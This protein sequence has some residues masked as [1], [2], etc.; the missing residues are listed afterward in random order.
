MGHSDSGVGVLAPRTPTALVL[1]AVL[2]LA[3]TPLL[4]LTLELLAVVSLRAW[5][6]K[7][8]L[9]A[10]VGRALLVDWKLFVGPAGALALLG[11]WVW[12][13]RRLARTGARRGRRV[14]FHAA[15]VALTLLTA[16]WR[17]GAWQDAAEREGGRRPNRLGLYSTYP[18]H[19]RGL[20]RSDKHG[21]PAAEL[22]IN[23][24]GFRDDAREYVPRP[25]VRR[26]LV[27]GDAFVFG[28][29]ISSAGD[30]LHAQLQTALDRAGGGPWEVMNLAQQPAALWYY[31]AALRA[32]LRAVHAD[33]LVL[34]H[35]RGF[36]LEPFE[37]RRLETVL[38]PGENAV[39][40]AFGIDQD[41]Q[42]LGASIGARAARG[43]GGGPSASG[44]AA[45]HAA[46]A[47]LVADADLAGA[48]LFVWE[49]LGHDPFFDP[50][51]ACPGVSFVAGDDLLG[52]HTTTRPWFWDAAL[53]YPDDGR[54]TPFANR[55]TAEGLARRIGAA[56]ASVAAR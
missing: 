46:V 13:G 16:F 29:G 9:P 43:E 15:L 12:I 49:P 34:T 1:A 32:A 37:L 18:P 40:R 5:L 21:V 8:A 7:V 33:V 42:W 20:E 26:V 30:L 36:D 48:H 23:A 50:F 53:A 3:W 56:G 35:L 28:R 39:V 54:P 22:S 55:L 51:R 10:E 6:W 17:F 24:E 27:V 41:V 45:L 14:A 11:A 52:P 38:T 31:T 47:H 25:G 44:L 4:A 19:F 2:A